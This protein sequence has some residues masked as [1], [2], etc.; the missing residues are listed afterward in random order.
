MEVVKRIQTNLKEYQKPLIALV[1]VEVFDVLTTI[2]GIQLGATEANPLSNTFGVYGLLTIKMLAVFA[3]VAW[4]ANSVRPGDKW[5]LWVVAG[6]F[7]LLPVWNL[8]ML[9]VQAALN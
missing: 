9:S 1:L 6:I 4:I 5:K 8:A 3:I 7:A 2:I